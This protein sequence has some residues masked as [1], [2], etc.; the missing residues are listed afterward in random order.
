VNSSKSAKLKRDQR[1]PRNKCKEQ[2]RNQECKAENSQK[3]NRTLIISIK[4]FP[5]VF[6]VL[7]SCFLFENVMF[8]GFV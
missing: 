8:G 7:D 2:K 1:N 5:Q 6:R 3:A 4:E